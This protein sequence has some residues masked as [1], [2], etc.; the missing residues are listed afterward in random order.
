[1]T[2]APLRLMLVDEDPVFRLGLRIW[3]EQTA[4]YAVVAEATQADDALA[5]LASRASLE[6]PP[7]AAP[8]WTPQP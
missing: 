8:D 1:M 2:T 5:I 3:L 7:D 4:G 6:N